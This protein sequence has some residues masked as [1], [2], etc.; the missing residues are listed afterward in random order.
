[1]TSSGWHIENIANAMS[2]IRQEADKIFMGVGRNGEVAA[3]ISILADSQTESGKI[4]LD[5]RNVIVNG[6]LTAGALSASAGTIAD[7]VSDQIVA[8]SINI[9]SLSFSH[10]DSSHTE[11]LEI[12]PTPF[13]QGDGFRGPLRVEAW[14]TDRPAID[15][16][17]GYVTGLKEKIYFSSMTP[18]TVGDHCRVYDNKVIISAKDDTDGVPPSTMVF[19]GDPGTRSIL[20][21]VPPLRQYQDGQCVTIVNSG[22]EPFSII[23]YGDYDTGESIYGLGHDARYNRT[24]SMSGNVRMIHLYKHGNEWRGAPV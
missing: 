11:S 20:I 22:Q 19:W 12:Q 9:G 6:G 2:T 14:D 17:S 15:I 3:S 18:N 4:I 23:G 1:M 21:E 10:S 7:I 8:G 24:Q 13:S 5:A 16:K